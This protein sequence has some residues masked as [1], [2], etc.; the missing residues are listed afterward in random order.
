MQRN[1]QNAWQ[2]DERTRKMVFPLLSSVIRRL[3]SVIRRLSQEGWSFF[4]LFL[5]KTVKLKD[6]PKLMKLQKA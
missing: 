4:V 3:P 6:G 1:R 2:D 5:L